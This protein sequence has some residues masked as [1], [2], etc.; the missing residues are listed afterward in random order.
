[1]P[2]GKGDG[3]R[4]NLKLK[5]LSNKTRNYICLHVIRRYQHVGFFF[6]FFFALFNNEYH[7]SF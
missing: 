1:M 5:F 7:A 3:E 4:R 2:L 6:F